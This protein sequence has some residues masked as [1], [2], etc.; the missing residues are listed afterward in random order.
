MLIVENIRSRSKELGFEKCGVARVGDLPKADFY[1]QWLA[2][3]MHG[4]MA[5]LEKV[6]PRYAPEELL[7][8]A[9]S[10]VCVLKNYYTPDEQSSDPLDGVIS[11]YAWGDDYHDLLKTRLRELRDWIGKE[12]GAEAKVCVDTSAVLEKLWARQA[13]IGWQ[14]KQNAIGRVEPR[15]KHMPT[16][17]PA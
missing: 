17:A 4:E 14:G 3:G 8:G 7:P 15:I 10:V 16:A 6:G 2:D 13:G 9:K 12:T 1:R 5:Y 11:R